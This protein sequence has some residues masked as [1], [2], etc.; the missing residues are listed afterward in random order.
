LHAGEATL[1]TAW[2]LHAIPDE[3]VCESGPIL[4]MTPEQEL[5]LILSTPN[6]A[7]PATRGAYGGYVGGWRQRLL[8]SH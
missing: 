4:E 6:G 5:Q 1:R 3:Q 8:H 7:T 2:A